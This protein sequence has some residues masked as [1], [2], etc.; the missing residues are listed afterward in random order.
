MSG[1]IP[2]VVSQQNQVVS[3][4]GS[5]QGI[6]ICIFE[7]KNTGTGATTNLTISIDQ[8]VGNASHLNIQSSSADFSSQNQIPNT[9]NCTSA[10]A[11][12][13]ITI[14]LN[15]ATSGEEFTI[16]LIENVTQKTFSFILHVT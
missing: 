5:D 7:L 14:L 2:D 4:A 1:G 6:V 11:W 13:C 9:G 8:I 15:G 3:I 10:T 12:P 16:T